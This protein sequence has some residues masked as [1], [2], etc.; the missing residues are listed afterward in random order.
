VLNAQDVIV[1]AGLSVRAVQLLGEFT[2]QDIIDK[3]AFSRSGDPGNA[4]EDPER[5]LNVDV[6][7]VVMARADNA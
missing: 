6:L 4:R 7:E 3:G 1:V 2:M 5:D